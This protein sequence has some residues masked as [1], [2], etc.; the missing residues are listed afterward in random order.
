MVR[1]TLHDILYSSGDVFLPESLKKFLAIDLVG[2]CRK[3]FYISNWS[4][5]HLL[6]GI[7]AGYILIYFNFSKTGLLGTQEY[8]LK[9]FAIHT[10]WE[11]WQIFIGMSNPLRL[12]GRSNIIDILIDTLLFM[13]G[14]WLIRQQPD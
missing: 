4:L 9:M 6:S 7:L 10:I 11:M 12:T 14:A 5:V 1:H 2:D 3:T 13:T 8:Y